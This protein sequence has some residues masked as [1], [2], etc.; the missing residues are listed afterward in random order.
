M[1]YSK[2]Y[3]VEHLLKEMSNELQQKRIHEI[4]SRTKGDV[5]DIGAGVGEI[6]I[7]L[8]EKGH[9]VTAF[10]INQN[11]V[12]YLKS[13]NINASLFD[14][15]KADS[16]PDADT[17][18]FGEILEHLKDP[19]QALSLACKHAR[20]KILITLPKV[21]DPWHY[22]YIDFVQTHPFLILELKKKGNWNE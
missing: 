1:D 3:S 22:W 6:S 10:D 9:K 13:K 14:V 11:Y 2:Y 7:P 17:I 19:G 18:I 5:I 8:Q 15:T 4:V 20:D 12:D 21:D 16:I